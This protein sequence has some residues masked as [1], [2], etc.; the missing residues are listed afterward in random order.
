ML[1]HHRLGVATTWCTTVLMWELMMLVRR[2]V[3]GLVRL[4]VWSTHGRHWDLVSDVECKLYD[5]DIL[6]PG[7]TWNI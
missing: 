6:D 2:T 5:A 1:L 4:W 7:G 3:M